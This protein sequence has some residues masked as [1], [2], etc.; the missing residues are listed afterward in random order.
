VCSSDLRIK[1]GITHIFL[2]FGL[3]FAKFYC[4][5]QKIVNVQTQGNGADEEIKQEFI[6]NPYS[7]PLSAIGRLFSARPWRRDDGYS[8]GFFATPEMDH[9]LIPVHADCQVAS[10]LVL[11]FQFGLSACL[12]KIAELKRGIERRMRYNE[13]KLISILYKEIRFD[14]ERATAKRGYL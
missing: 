14:C 12:G 4:V 10:S 11:D 13:K 6:S 3:V 5:I 7:E 2:S 9:L 8:N 1:V